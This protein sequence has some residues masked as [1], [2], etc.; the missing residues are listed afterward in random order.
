M[1]TSFLPAF[2]I[3]IGLEGK[4]T[5]DQDDPG[6]FTIWGLASKFHPNVTKDT[7]LEQAQEIYL[8]EYW[9]ASGCDSLAFPMDICVFDARVNPQNDPSLP[10]GSMQELMDL[11]PE[12]WQ[13]YLF[14]RMERYQRCSKSKYVEGHKN[15]ILR[16]HQ[17]IKTLE[18]GV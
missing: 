5:D 8:N 18:R 13:D 15:R 4:P 17:Q 14:F 3:V 11:N 7:T 12:N 2:K 6:G 1:R 10:G 16:L 9:S